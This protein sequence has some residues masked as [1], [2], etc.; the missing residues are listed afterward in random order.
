MK[1][2]TVKNIGYT[3]GRAFAIVTAV[4]AMTIVAGITV[5]FLYEI[6]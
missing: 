6:L 3:L 1:I 2:K 5:T 4:S